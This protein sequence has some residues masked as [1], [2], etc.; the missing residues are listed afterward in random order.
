M[1]TAARINTRLWN[2]VWERNIRALL[3]LTDNTFKT[4]LVFKKK[5]RR[6][7][8]RSGKVICN[9]CVW[10]WVFLCRYA[11]MLGFMCMCMCICL[12]ACL[13]AC[14]VCWFVCFARSLRLFILAHNSSLSQ[15]KH[16]L[17]P[18]LSSL[19]SLS[20]LPAPPWSLCRRLYFSRHYLLLL[21]SSS[22]QCNRPFD[23]LWWLY[24]VTLMLIAKAWPFVNC[25][26]HCL[27]TR[28]AA[29]VQRFFWY[30]CMWQNLYCY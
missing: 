17:N 30:C 13:C 23:R 6:K 22:M 27:P 2:I 16:M 21:F 14:F 20:L 18:T 9:V 29:H 11:A 24:S 28:F 1:N 26:A 12:C 15:A 19:L 3:Q 4:H 5:R 10:N 25:I 8:S 7:K